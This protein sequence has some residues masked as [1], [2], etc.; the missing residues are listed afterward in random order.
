MTSDDEDRARD[1]AIDE[2]IAAANRASGG[3]RRVMVLDPDTERPVTIKQFAAKM[4]WSY[5]RARGWAI[6]QGRLLGG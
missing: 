1:R 5:G 2:A 3:R 6:R 4:D